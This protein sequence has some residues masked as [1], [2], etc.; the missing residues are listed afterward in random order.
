MPKSERVGNFLTFLNFLIMKKLM[1]LAP[2]LLAFTQ[3]NAQSPVPPAEHGCC[4][5]YNYVKNGNF[6]TGTATFGSDKIQNATNWESVFS[7]LSGGDYWSPASNPT[8]PVD[9]P[10]GATGRWAGLWSRANCTEIDYRE[11]I[12]GKLLQPITPNTGKCCVSL[13]LARDVAHSFNNGNQ[14]HKLEVY[15]YKGSL[16][17][18]TNSAS[19]CPISNSTILSGA[20]HLTLLATFDIRVNGSSPVTNKFKTFT[21][22]FNSSILNGDID[23]III[24]RKDGVT[25]MS[26]IFVDNVKVSGYISPCDK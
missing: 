3:T 6:E 11:G 15:G 16:P 5:E 21:Q 1:F 13:D 8:T 18:I 4:Q 26:Y 10:N 17:Q 14:V 20:T 7:G 2:F 25:G 12:K 23:G 19:N 24:T 22:Q 9:Q